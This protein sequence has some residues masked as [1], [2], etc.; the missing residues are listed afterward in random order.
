MEALAGIGRLPP[1]HAA[2]AAAT[3]TADSV[4]GDLLRRIIA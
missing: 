3:A 2:N 1:P 4:D